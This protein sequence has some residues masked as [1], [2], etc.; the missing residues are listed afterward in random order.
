MKHLPQY[1][2][3]LAIL[4]LVLP[5]RAA[6]TVHYVDLNSTNAT[7]PYSDWATAATSIQDAVDAAVAG[8]E[9]VVTNGTYA[10][11]G[12]P[13]GPVGFGYNRV[14]VSKPLT[15]RSMSGP[16]FTTIYGGVGLRC[17]CLS[18]GASL[19]GFTL[20]RATVV[21][22]SGAGVACASGDAVVSN[23]VI[24]WN[25]AWSASI[26]PTVFPFGGGAYGVTLLNCTLAHNTASFRT[27]YTY[28][29]YYG[30]AYGGGAYACT[31]N[32]CTLTDNSVTASASRDSEHLLERGG[33]AAQC[34][35][36]NCALTW[37]SAAGYSNYRY[38]TSEADG[39]G[40][41]ESTL[42]N[43][44]LFN[45]SHQGICED[46]NSPGS[47]N[48][49]NW[50]GDPLF[51]DTNGWADLRLQSNSPC[52]NAGD[53]AFAPA[54]PDLDGNPRIVGGTVDIGA[55]EYQSLSLINF[56]VVSNRVA[57]N[58]TG[59]SNQVVTVET[60]TDLLNWSPLATN[61]LNGHAFPFNDPMPATLPQR[62]YRAQPQ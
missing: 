38:T 48:G 5:L 3:T 24:A 40:A 50:I 47:L 59:Q 46:C 22:G 9:I 12:G 14:W 7:P 10:S 41:Y 2:L 56:G 25:Q 4:L 61:T 32:N 37:N 60:S 28:V 39:G 43:C 33:G 18:D 6:S 42:N 45:N 8:D 16:A 58:V 20:A 55:Y 26:G 1:L 17:V 54:G 49:G 62:F 23:C 19:S 44:I 52:I 29:S 36:N 13:P 15:V 27:N 11:G 21:N 35:L 51:V 31:L 53:N 57:F 30:E 34:T